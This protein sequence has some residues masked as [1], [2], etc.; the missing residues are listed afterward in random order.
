MAK[1][2]KL[3][4]CTQCKY[5]RMACLRYTDGPSIGEHFVLCTYDGDFQVIVGGANKVAFCCPLSD[6]PEEKEQ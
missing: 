3:D 2:M 6:A 5:H 1:I 4:N